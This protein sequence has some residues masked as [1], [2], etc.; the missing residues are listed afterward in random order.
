MFFQT[1]VALAA[2]AFALFGAA[3]PPAILYWLIIGAAVWWATWLRAIIQHGPDV[4]VTFNPSKVWYATGAPQNDHG[5]YWRLLGRW[6][7]RNFIAAR[8]RR[9]CDSPVCSRQPQGRIQGRQVGW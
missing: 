6:L 9:Q 1:V 3:N 4:K 5:L 2:I 8:H 7:Y